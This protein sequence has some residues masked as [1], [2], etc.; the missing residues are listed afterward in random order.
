MI[1]SALT[2]KTSQFLRDFS[3]AI[4]VPNAL[5]LVDDEPGLYAI[6]VDDPK[7]LPDP[8]ASIL[9]ARCSSPLRGPCARLA[10]GQAYRPGTAP[11][12]AATFFR[13]IGA[14]LG[15]RPQFG[16]L[17]GKANQKNYRFSKADTCQIVSWME[18]HLRVRWLR[19]DDTDLVQVEPAVIGELRPMLNTKHNPDRC[20]ELAELRSCA[21]G[22]HAGNEAARLCRDRGSEGSVESLRWSVPHTA[23][24]SYLPR[25]RTQTTGRVVTPLFG[26]LRPHDWSAELIGVYVRERIAGRVQFQL[27]SSTRPARCVLGR[28]GLPDKLG[29]S[30]FVNPFHPA[31]G[32]L[33]SLRVSFGTGVF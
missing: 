19:M 15:F 31:Q 12:I 25:E 7:S 6:F 16:S 10:I 32:F 18:K 33:P 4:S 2:T 13:G 8:F 11:Q 23:F 3:A 1:P 24:T 17:R 14:I 9:S 20:N 21:G 29:Y 26:F 30:N 5:R 27:A 22:S 28:R